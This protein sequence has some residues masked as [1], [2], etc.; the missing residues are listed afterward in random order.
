MNIGQAAA[1]SGVSAKM[2]RYYEAT[3][4]VSPAGRSESGYRIYGPD[5]IHRLGFIR[6]ARNLGFTIEQ[7]G[8]LLSLWQDR[9]RPSR[10]V[11]R[12]AEAHLDH[13]RDKIREIQAMVDTLETLAESCCGDDRPDCPIL[14]DLGATNGRISGLA[15]PQMRRLNSI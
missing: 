7:I 4:L 11:K 14:R 1:A 15:P 8:E 9:S 12:I 5:D 6:R 2:I 13:L 10:D 3:G